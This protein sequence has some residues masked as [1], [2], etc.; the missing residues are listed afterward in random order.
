MKRL[1]AIILAVIMMS[2]ILCGALAEL[3]LSYIRENPDLYT[4]DVSDSGEAAFIETALNTAGRSFTHKYES[5]NRYN[6]TKFDILVLDYLKTSAY[7][8]MR[9]WI[10]YCAD[11]NYMNINSVSFIID[12]TKYTFSGVADP[13][14][15]TKDDSGYM[16]QILIRFNQENISFLAAMIGQIT[17]D[18]DFDQLLE[19]AECKMILHG[20]EDIEVDLG[21]GFFLDYYAI[22]NA[23]LQIDGFE[24]LDKSVGT[25]MKETTP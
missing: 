6:S 4:I 18:G 19:S 15:Y 25:T 23:M 8:V 10:T 3:D 9:L 22:A 13:E 5:A 7:P 2:A 12:G 24:Y 16:E 17:G 21:Q 14:W 20:R 11:D 1:L